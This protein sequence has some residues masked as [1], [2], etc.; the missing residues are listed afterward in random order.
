M[1]DMTIQT[2]IDIAEREFANGYKKVMVERYA[3]HR[4]PNPTRRHLRL[5]KNGVGLYVRTGK[6]GTCKIYLKDM[7]D[8]R[9]VD[10]ELGVIVFREV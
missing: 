1:P 4:I 2:A 9:I 8:A 3:T 10:A 5:F 7:A 6:R